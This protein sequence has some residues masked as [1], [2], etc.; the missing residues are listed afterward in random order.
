[1][2]DLDDKKY[3]KLKNFIED[4]YDESQDWDYVRNVKK[5]DGMAMPKE[6]ILMGFI[7]SLTNIP[8]A[9][10][11]TC[12]D[13]AIDIMKARDEQIKVTKLGKAIKSDAQIPTDNH[14]TWKLYENKLLA[15]GWSNQS[16][17]DIK[18]SSFE[19]LQNLSM[20][21]YVDPT[22]KSTNDNEP[23]KGLV[24]GNVQSGKTA[25]MAGV[26]AMAADNGFNYFIIMSGVIENLRRQTANRIYNDMNSYGSANLHWNQVEHP[27]LRSKNP[28]LDI[29]KFNLAEGDRDRYFTVTLKNKGR[30]TKLKNWLFS[31]VNKARQLKVLIIDDEADQASVNTKNLADED[32]TAINKVIRDIVYA[33]KVKGMNYIAYTAT[34]YANIL[35]ETTKDSLYPSDFI[36]LL[37]PSTDY[38]GPKQLFGIDEP[39]QSPS[40]DII[41]PIPDSESKELQDNQKEGKEDELPKSFIDAIQWFLL[42]VSAMRSLDYEKPISMLVHTSF[43]IAAHQLTANEITDYLRYLKKHYAVIKPD[44]KILYENERLDFKR[45]HFLKGLSDYSTPNTVPE[46]PE[47]ADVEQNLD[48]LVRLSD[49]EYVSHIKIGEEGQATYHKGIHLVIDNSQSRADDQI[50]RLVYPD[51]KQTPAPAFIVIG[52]NTLSRGLTLEGLVATYFLRTTNQADTLMQ[53]GRW[54][55][56]R[57]GYEIFPRIWLDRKAWQ[58]Y[59]FLSQ[60]N[61][62]LREEIEIYETKGL[63]PAEYAPKVKMSPNNQ[64]IKITSNKKMQSAQASD[65]NFE[66]FNSQTIYFENDEV[67]LRKN[68]AATQSF[69]NKLEKPEFNGSNMIWHDVSIEM[70]N[71][72]LTDYHVSPLDI[73]MSSLPA[74]TK[75]VREYSES[76]AAWSVILASK[77]EIPLA[78]KDTE[79]N[80]QGYSPN[81]V[82]RTKL[83][84]RSTSKIANIGTLRSPADLFADIPNLSSN[85]KISTKPSIV[86]TIRLNEGYGDV[87]QLIIY[88]IDKGNSNEHGNDKINKTRELLDFPTDL[89]GINI[90]IPGISKRDNLATY[91]SARLDIDADYVVEEEED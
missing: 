77:G 3:A 47:W 23:I 33:N 71:S 10:I 38:I 67:N 84:N 14:S 64:L 51:K 66:G 19:I 70:V 46:Y 62:E 54:F 7:A 48:R 8:S 5:F 90:M 17:N 79:W 34:P 37:N 41:R 4:A 42:S 30:L 55:G 72:F 13:E 6:A 22:D 50:V 83:K 75:W 45:S 86:Q 88:R 40:I 91:V 80:I 69:L 85:K 25:N 15:Q 29:S 78:K 89:I 65:Y 68:L 11:C 1:M 82:F 44:M 57:K 87:P 43:K 32:R 35:N 61:E 9:E 18:K 56:Y 49:D 21:T 39:E 16:V 63:T 2:M 73:K 53:M 52:G 26:M 59:Q 31:D 60:M 76:M 74:L 24:I 27:Q 20:D 12:W 36:T 81:P 28:E 58:R